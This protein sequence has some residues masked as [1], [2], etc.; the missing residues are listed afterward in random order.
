M[1]VSN[2][3]SRSRAIAYSLFGLALLLTAAV[4]W[5]SLRG[6]Y[7]FDDFP[8]IVDNRD[9]HPATLDRVSLQAALLSSPSAVLVRPLAMLSFAL[10]WHVSGGDPYSM[11]LV[12]LGIHLLNG[13]LLF[14]LLRSMARWLAPDDRVRAD[15]LAA[16]VAGVWL[17]A[18]INFTAVAYIVQRMESLCQIFVLGGLWGYVAARV[19]MRTRGSGFL[20]AC[21]AIVLGTA[22]GGLAKESAALLP[23]YALI[24]EW[25][26]FDFKGSHDKPDRRLY[27]M[28]VVIL[29]IPACA[30]A[31][32]IWRHALPEAAWANRPFTLVERLLTEPRIVLDYARW[33][34][35]PTPDAL[36]LYHDQIAISRGLFAPVSTFASVASLTAAAVLA[37]CARRRWPLACIGVLW[38]LAAHLITATVI[39]LELAYEH[40]N[41][42]ASAGLYLAVFSVVL[43]A[44]ADM[45]FALPRVAA[46][47][48][49]AALFACVT[50]IRALD[51]A[52]PLSLAVSE[53]EK[54]PDS[55]RTAYELGRMYVILSGYRADSPLVPEAYA[56]LE[57]AATMPG[58]DALPDQGIVLLSARL[59]R[60][61]PHA[62]WARLQKKLRTQPI[63]AQNINGLSALTQCAVDGAC[64]LPPAEMIACFGAALERAQ[65]DSHVLSAYSNYAVNVLH[66]I[67]LAIELARAT[68]AQSPQDLQARKNL[69]LLLTVSGQHDAARAFYSET[70]RDLPQAGEDRAFRDLLQTGSDR[71]P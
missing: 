32:W 59:H 12:N 25:V 47:M 53:A 51:W 10:N 2:P 40:R 26:L 8:N 38:F 19:R 1:T 29:A 60:E 58:A 11:K 45:H 46:C 70:L 5:P 49:L 28:Y 16:A 27:A 48:A 42:F 15:L 22:C 44:T 33:S 50:W 39:P 37:V 69:L 7:V 23:L 61:I 3:L 62:V 35:L 17:L 30:A 36:A 21:A 41:Y 34:L 18:P 43:P 6:G 24:V 56:A 13:L 67:A 71:T 55:P 52:N 63:S 65:P 14:G 66:D 64:Q 54:N 20:A 9:V 4:Y 57:H 31:F 68:V